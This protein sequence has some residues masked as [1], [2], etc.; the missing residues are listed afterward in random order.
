MR[1]WQCRRGC[2]VFLITTSWRLSWTS[3]EKARLR[4]LSSWFTLLMT[5]QLDTTL[6]PR[7]FILIISRVRKM[8]WC[9]WR[10]QSLINIIFRYYYLFHILVTNYGE[11]I[12]HMLA[13]SCLK[14]TSNGDKLWLVPEKTPERSNTRDVSFA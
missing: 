3:K 7:N 2:E 13:D 9:W 10:F 6:I 5:S 4:R 8:D 11:F 14:V 1:W 12:A